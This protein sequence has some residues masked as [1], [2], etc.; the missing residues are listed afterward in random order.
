MGKLLTLILT[1]ACLL[2][3]GCGDEPSASREPSLEARWPSAEE[4]TLR[5][6]HAPTPFTADQIRDGCRSGRR[7]TFFTE[8]EADGRGFLVF[9]FEGAD[10]EGVT[11]TV[12]FL[13]EKRQP[14]RVPQGMRTTWQELQSHAS[15]PS[16]RTTVRDEIVDVPAGAF[17]CLVYEVTESDTGE[18]VTTRYDFARSLPGMPVRVVKTRGGR[19][20]SRQEL[21][22]DEPGAGE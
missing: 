1:L 12:E 14:K 10:A 2:G 19:V 11:F 15:F 7:S 17:A 22:T 9:L 21:V 16:G 6:G 4:R 3:A 13:D 18:D 5:D 20:V 8:S